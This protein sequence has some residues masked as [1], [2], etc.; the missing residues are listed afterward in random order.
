[1]QMKSK[2]SI[3]SIL[4]MMATFSLSSCSW[5]MGRGDD[6]D[7]N[8]E[9]TTLAR[10]DS[11]KG[12]EY[13]GLS[14]TRDLEDGKFQAVVVYNVLDSAGKMVER[15]ARVTTNNDGS[16]IYTW[17]DLDC[18]VLGEVKQ[19]VSDKLEEKGINIDGSLIDALIELKRR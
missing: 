17:E 6:R 3:A 10:L 15:N 12:V 14:D 2:N 18:Q 7:N 1:M 11:V 8:L 4:I 13:I 9:K 19:K 16:E 5:N